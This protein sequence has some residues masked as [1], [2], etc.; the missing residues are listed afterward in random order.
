M[1]ARHGPSTQPENDTGPVP[2]VPPSDPSGPADVDTTAETAG[3]TQ[4]GDDA[5]EAIPQ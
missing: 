5:T 1:I 4:T 3:D 2:G